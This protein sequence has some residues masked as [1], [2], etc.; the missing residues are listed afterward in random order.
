MS[1]RSKKSWINKTV[2]VLFKPW[3]RFRKGKVAFKGAKCLILHTVGAKTGKA[4]ETPL[5]YLETEPGVL[6]IVG[7]NGGDDKTPAWVHN[8]GKQPAVDVEVAG[9]KQSMT[10]SIADSDTRGELWPSL[11]AMYPAYATYQTKTTREIPV[12]LLHSTTAR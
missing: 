12:I 3:F 10:A 1:D 11:V 6:A 9:A 2:N 7:S 8:L 4:R 5:L